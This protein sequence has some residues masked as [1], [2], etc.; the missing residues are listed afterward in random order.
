M[1]R[2]R[3]SEHFARFLNSSNPRRFMDREA[4]NVIAH[5]LHLTGINPDRIAMPSRQT[6][7]LIARPHCTGERRVELRAC[8][9]YC[10]EWFGTDHEA[11][12]TGR[13]FVD[14]INP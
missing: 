13:V 7:A 11:I 10:F 3:G 5:Q 9:L 1:R 8:E 14:T 12:V 4:Q 6:L 2:G